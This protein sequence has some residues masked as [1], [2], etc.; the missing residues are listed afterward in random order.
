MTCVDF[1]PSYPLQ[2]TL[3]YYSGF[4]F[5]LHHARSFLTNGDKALFLFFGFFF[6]LCIDFFFYVWGKLK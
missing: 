5:G 4:N 2:D 1:L 6:G 3:A